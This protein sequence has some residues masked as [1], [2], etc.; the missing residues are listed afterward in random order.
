MNR[1]L[2]P[3]ELEIINKA[4]E[5]NG[6]ASDVLAEHYAMIMEE[7]ENLLAITPAALG[8]ST[9]NISAEEISVIK[10]KVTDDYKQAKNTFSKL[11][12]KSGRWI[13]SVLEDI[14]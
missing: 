7:A 11:Y 10:V 5:K 2:T 12:S 6:I 3:S 4:A 14:K 8:N 1:Q 13:A 9:V